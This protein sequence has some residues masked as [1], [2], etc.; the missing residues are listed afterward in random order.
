M[1][2]S[3]KARFRGRR[4]VAAP[5]PCC[6]YAATMPSL[7]LRSSSVLWERTYIGGIS[8]VYR[9]YTC[10]GTELWRKKSDNRPCPRLS[11]PVPNNFPSPCVIQ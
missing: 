3:F 10:F 2:F 4:A 8:E 6:R 1:A 5:P 11:V 7:R 9:T